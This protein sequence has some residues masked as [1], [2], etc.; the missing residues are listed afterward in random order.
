[1]PQAENQKLQLYFE[2]LLPVVEMYPGR[3][4]VLGGGGTLNVMIQQGV[5]EGIITSSM[6]KGAVGFGEMTAE[7]FVLPSACLT[8]C[9]WN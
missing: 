8:S 1:M 7:H 2:D 9:H 6:G 3:F 5:R 4:A